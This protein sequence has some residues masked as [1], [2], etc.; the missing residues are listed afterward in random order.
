MCVGGE[1]HSVAAQ[2]QLGQ[3]PRLP[4]LVLDDVLEPDHGSTDLDPDELGG[5]LVGRMTSGSST[6][7]LPDCSSARAM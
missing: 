2:S 3:R 5:L 6:V 4:V 1:G 7:K